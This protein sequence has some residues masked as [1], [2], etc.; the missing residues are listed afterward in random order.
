MS[1]QNLIVGNDYH[2]CNVT[3][4]TTP[5]TLTELLKTANPKGLKV[6]RE[7]DVLQVTI[8]PASAILVRDADNTVDLSVSSAKTFPLLNPFDRI[9]LSCAAA[10]V[11]C[12]VE[13]ISQNHKRS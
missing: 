7:V 9:K 4:T 5:T 1:D 11:A 8:Y 2:V 3:V 10:T 6:D 13:W 12:A